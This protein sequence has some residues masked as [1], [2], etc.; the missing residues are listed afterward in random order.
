M[1]KHAILVCAVAGYGTAVL[2]DQDMTTP[3]GEANCVVNAR[4]RLRLV[5][6]RG[7]TAEA[8]AQCWAPYVGCSAIIHTPCTS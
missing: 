7:C 3:H 2:L 4:D 8:L 6:L 1:P 5:H